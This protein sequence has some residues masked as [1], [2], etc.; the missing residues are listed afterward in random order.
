VAN[1]FDRYDLCHAA[2]SRSPGLVL[3]DGAQLH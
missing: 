2:P 3:L 1:P